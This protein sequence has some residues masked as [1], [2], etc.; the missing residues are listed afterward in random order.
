MKKHCQCP[1]SKKELIVLRLILFK[2]LILC[3][4]DVHY[5]RRKTIKTLL[6][7][8]YPKIKV[9]RRH[10][11][12]YGPFGLKISVTFYKC[13]TLESYT[14]NINFLLNVNIY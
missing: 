10:H 13:V 12:D 14:F 6:G 4:G 3:K 7:P 8:K 9:N 1:F 11:Y 5:V 2:K